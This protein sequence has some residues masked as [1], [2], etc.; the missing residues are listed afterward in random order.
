MVWYKAACH[1]TKYIFKKITKEQYHKLLTNNKSSKVFS[2]RLRKTLI[3]FFLPKDNTIKISII[4][5][6]SIIT[7]NQ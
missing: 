5:H 1:K 4:Q 3:T 2:A 6:N 7:L